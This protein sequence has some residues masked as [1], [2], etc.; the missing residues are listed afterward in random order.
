[1]EKNN[2]TWSITSKEIILTEYKYL[3]SFYSHHNTNSYWVASLFKNSYWKEADVPTIWSETNVCFFKNTFE[4]IYA[5]I[6]AKLI[7][8]TAL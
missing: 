1:M 6:Y 5:N 2:V 3:S 7:I 8:A 4:N